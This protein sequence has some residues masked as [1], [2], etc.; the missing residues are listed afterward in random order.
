[1]IA[2]PCHASRGRDQ[3]VPLLPPLLVPLL[4]PLLVPLL[5]PLLVPLLPPL[6][7]PLLPPLLVPLLPPPVGSTGSCGPA[8]SKTSTVVC[9]C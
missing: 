6:L 1:L 7:V 5:P 2:L 8:A 4:P 9:T 3:L